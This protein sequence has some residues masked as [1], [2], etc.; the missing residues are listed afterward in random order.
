MVVFV[1]VFVYET[2]FCL[3]V[4]DKMALRL[5]DQNGE[6]ETGM[7]EMSERGREQPVSTDDGKTAVC[8]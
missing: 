7:R 6:R 3:F 2:R 8:R 1:V 4:V 5:V